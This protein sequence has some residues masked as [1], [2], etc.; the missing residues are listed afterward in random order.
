M[1]AAPT[2]EVVRAL[3][4]ADRNPKSNVAVVLLRTLFGAHG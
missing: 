4:E 2:K 3:V 1:A